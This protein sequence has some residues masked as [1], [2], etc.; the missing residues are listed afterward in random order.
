LFG[1]AIIHLTWMWEVPRLYLMGSVTMIQFVWEAK[2]YLM[3]WKITWQNL[4]VN[5]G[6]EGNKFY[7]EY[8]HS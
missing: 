4:C 3:M 5:V 7:G 8:F 2:H 1:L 6:K